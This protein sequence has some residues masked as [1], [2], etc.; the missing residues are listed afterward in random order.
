[1]SDELWRAMTDAAATVHR[2]EREKKALADELKARHAASL[3]WTTQMERMQA[4]N[5][6][7]RA[8]LL[9]VSCGGYGLPDHV[10]EQIRAALGE[11]A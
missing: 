11:A 10:Q 9:E 7:M 5:M 1:M 2:L 6:R 8:L 3:A 4:A